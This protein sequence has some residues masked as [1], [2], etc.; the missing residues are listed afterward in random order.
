MVAPDIDRAQVPAA[1]LSVTPD[2][3]G[4]DGSGLFIERERVFCHQA[5]RPPV[6]LIVRID[7]NGFAVDISRGTALVPVQ[8]SAVGRPG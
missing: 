3:F 2:C 1:M 6:P 5:R 7:A 4:N 8:P